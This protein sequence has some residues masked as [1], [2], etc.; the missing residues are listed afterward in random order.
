MTNDNVLKYRFKMTDVQHSKLDEAQQD[1]CV[2]TDD[3]K[4]PFAVVLSLDDAEVNAALDIMDSVKLL[5]LAKKTYIGALQRAGREAVEIE[6]GL[7]A[8]SER[9]VA[10]DLKMFNEA[11][12]TLDSLYASKA[13][14]D[15]GYA[16]GLLTLKESFGVDQS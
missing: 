4:K 6:F 7:K 5:E 11:K 3:P 1:R 12:K 2:G 13:L 14:T 15:D 8:K 9:F 16:S 10:H